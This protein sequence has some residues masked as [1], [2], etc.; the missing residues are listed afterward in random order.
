MCVA[1]EVAFHVARRHRKATGT[2]KN[3]RELQL[4]WFLGPIDYEIRAQGVQAD[5]VHASA[6]RASNGIINQPTYHRRAN[7]RQTD[8]HHH[9]A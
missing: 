9:H 1:Q 8:H 2:A 3:A 4:A 6:V 5:G 7:S